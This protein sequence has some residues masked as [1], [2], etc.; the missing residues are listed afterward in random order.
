MLRLIL[1]GQARDLEI[2]PASASRIEQWEKD[3]AEYRAVGMDASWVGAPPK[4]G[5]SF[6]KL[7]R[8]IF[9][10]FSLLVDVGGGRGGVRPTVG[11]PRIYAGESPICQ[12]GG[13]ED[14]LSL[15][16]CVDCESC[17]AVCKPFYQCTMSRMT[18]Q[19][20]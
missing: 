15:V 4:P 17:E 5:Q 8:H 12:Y 9:A 14:G 3:P 18:V 7:L 6:I 1:A 19:M 10:S 2:A 20:I 13:L 16:G 11:V